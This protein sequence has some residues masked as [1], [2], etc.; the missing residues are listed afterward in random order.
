MNATIKTTEINEAVE[1]FASSGFDANEMRSL[2]DLI[3]VQTDYVQKRFWKLA[4]EAKAEWQADIT[5][6]L[7]SL[8]LR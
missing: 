1:A 7:E 8:G 5:D 2:M 6:T 3:E 4:D